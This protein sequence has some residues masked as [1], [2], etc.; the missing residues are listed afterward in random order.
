MIGRTEYHTTWVSPQNLQWRKIHIT[1]PH[2]KVIIWILCQKFWLRHVSLVKLY[3][4]RSSDVIF[5]QNTELIK[6]RSIHVF[7]CYANDLRTSVGSTGQL[8]RT[9]THNTLTCCAE[10]GV[11]VINNMQKHS[12]LILSWHG[13][14]WC[15]IEIIQ[16]CFYKKFFFFFY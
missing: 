1:W 2:A 16:L 14:K 7:T 10:C 9:H 12:A 4:L 3:M 5:V 13:K 6:K 15:G 8:N 11:V